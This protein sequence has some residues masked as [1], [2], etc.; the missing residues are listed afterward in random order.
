MAD[1]EQGAAPAEGGVDV[2]FWIVGVV[3]LVIVIGGL[4]YVSN[5]GTA[6]A[7]KALEAAKAAQVKLDESGAVVISAKAFVAKVKADNAD[8]YQATVEGLSMSDQKNIRKLA[9]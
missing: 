7:D 5:Q 8:V 1:N 9:E 2:K 6:A 3:V 4:F